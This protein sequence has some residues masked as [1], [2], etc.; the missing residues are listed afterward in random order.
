MISLWHHFSSTDSECSAALVRRELPVP[1]QRLAG[2][3]YYPLWG[4]AWRSCIRQH[5]LLHQQGGQDRFPSTVF[6]NHS[7]FLHCSITWTIS[8]NRTLAGG[9]NNLMWNI[10]VSPATGW[11]QTEGVFHGDR[12]CGRQLGYS[13][14]C[15][16]CVPCAQIFLF[17]VTQPTHWPTGWI[18]TEQVYF[19]KI[20]FCSLTWFQHGIQICP[21]ITPVFL[22]ED[23]Y[24]SFCKTKVYT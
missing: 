20:L 1:A 15:I 7:S 14:G 17:P 2:V 24:G 16:T 18:S 13:C 9:S 6:W 19:L 12:Q 5:L 21:R 23:R 3:C 10:L 8:G 11:R 4:F 22:S